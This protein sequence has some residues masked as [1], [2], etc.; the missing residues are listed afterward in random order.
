VQEVPWPQYFSARRSART[1]NQITPLSSTASRDIVMRNPPKNALNA[2]MKHWGWGAALV[3]I[4]PARVVRCS[5]KKFATVKACAVGLDQ[6]HSSRLL[7]AHPRVPP[8]AANWTFGSSAGIASASREIHGSITAVTCNRQIKH[9]GLTVIVFEYKGKLLKNIEEKAYRYTTYVH[10]SSGIAKSFPV[11]AYY[12]S[13]DGGDNLVFKEGL[14]SSFL[15]A[16]GQE[17]GRLTWRTAAGEEILSWQ[18]QGTAKARDVMRRV[19]NL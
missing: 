13:A 12:T 11:I 18:L 8:T 4:A 1:P 10:E 5:V 7:R 15:E 6:R 19:C 3:G 17:D 16:F 14:N 2:R 9:V